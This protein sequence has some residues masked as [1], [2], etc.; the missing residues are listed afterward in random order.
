M[1]DIRNYFSSVK[2]KTKEKEDKRVEVSSKA[3]KKK[4]ILDSDDDEDP[5]PPK[6]K[7]SVIDLSDSG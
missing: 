6:K 4:R 3:I 1:Q 5:R 2:A 7:A